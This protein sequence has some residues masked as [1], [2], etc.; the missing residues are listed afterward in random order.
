MTIQLSFWCLQYPRIFEIFFPTPC[1]SLL[2]RLLRLFVH[3]TNI[4]NTGH[5]NRNLS[6]STFCFHMMS[7]FSYSVLRSFCG[8]EV[9]SSELRR[10]E[11]Y[12]PYTHRT[13]KFHFQL[14]AKCLFLF[15]QGEYR[16]HPTRRQRISHRLA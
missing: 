5:R 14:S 8:A 4:Q 10:A 15:C 9:R 12:A 3:F 11:R 16:E 6:L 1:P 7:V 13:A 2:F